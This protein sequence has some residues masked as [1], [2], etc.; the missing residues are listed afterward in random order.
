MLSGAPS[1]SLLASVLMFDAGAEEMHTYWEDR[2]SQHKASALRRHLVRAFLLRTH[3]C[4]LIPHALSQSTEFSKIFPLL[5][6]ILATV[7][8][9]HSDGLHKAAIEALAHFIEWIDDDWIDSA[10]VALI[11]PVRFPFSCVVRCR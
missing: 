9:G 2:I 11:L 10:L 7:G 5:T 1:W 3:E 8:Q 4:L 6:S